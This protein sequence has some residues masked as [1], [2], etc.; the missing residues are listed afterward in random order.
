MVTDV[1]PPLARS[2]DEAHLF[3]E[4]HPCVCG[5]V[6]FGG[7]S[8]VVEVDG[9]WISRY[10][11]PCEGCDRRRAFEFRQPDEIT[12][13]VA[14][15][16]ADGGP[17]ELIDAGQWLW[18]ADVYASRPSDVDE[19]AD[20]LLAAGALD[21]VWKFLPDGEAEVPSSAFWTV[22]GREVRDTEPGRFRRERLAAARETYRRL[23][24][25]PQ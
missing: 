4:L 20:L 12:V 7:V 15:S 13:P 24:G 3:M 10:A 18:V 2:S 23:V 8:S 19:R 9:V 11:G 14:G 5:E 1:A 6:E 22:R 25:A 16:W 17:S 21:E